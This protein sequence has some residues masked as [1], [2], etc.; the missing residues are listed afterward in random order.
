MLL[1][2]TLKVS[3]VTDDKLILVHVVHRIELN[4]VNETNIQLRTVDLLEKAVNSYLC[5]VVCSPDVLQ[6][7]RQVRNRADV[8]QMAARK[9]MPTRSSQRKASIFIALKLGKHEN[10][11]A[12]E[13]SKRR[14]TRPIGL[15]FDD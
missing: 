15:N 1:R 8:E 11:S 4:R 13:S 10:G 7:E 6:L 2:R 9:T 3:E 12:A 5:L 14:R